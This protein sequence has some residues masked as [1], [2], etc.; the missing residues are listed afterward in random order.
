MA[1]PDFFVMGAPKAGTT[2]LHTALSRHP[3]LFMSRVKEPRYFLTDDGVPPPSRGGPGDPQTYQEYVYRRRDYEELFAAAP[4]DTIKGE[5]S[6]FY[7]WSQ[8]AHRRIRAA[9]PDA[10]LIALLRDPVERAHSNWGHLWSAGL[11]PIN[12]F[13]QACEQESQRV[14]AG[15]APFWRYV[16]LGLYGKQIE[17]LL[18]VF[19]RNQVL[20]LRYRDVRE[21]PAQTLDR[22]CDF[23]GVETGV[24]STVPRENVT[25]QVPE[26]GVTRVI[27]VSLRGG[28]AFGHL[29]PLPLRRLV[30]GPLL[31]LLH[32]RPN[33]RQP[34]TVHEREQVLRY[35]E[36][37]IEVL[38]R[39]TGLS[40]SDWLATGVAGRGGLLMQG[41]QTA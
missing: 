38:Q 7:L 19:P 32:R 30:R 4:P 12:D 40:F 1:L 3:Q 5:S 8:D 33:A 2:A 24:I 17:H 10:R 41:G 11:E 28:A 14:A 16:D 9:V 15:W 31:H 22:I 23:L 39:V 21:Q 25:T 27:Q 29:F 20:L 18:E 37:D 13:V 35:F 34:L 6:P 36:A 26:T